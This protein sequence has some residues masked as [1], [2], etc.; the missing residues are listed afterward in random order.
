M[1]RIQSQKCIRNQRNAFRIQSMSRKHCFLQLCTWQQLL[2]FL[3]QSVLLAQW[4]LNPRKQDARRFCQRKA[5]RI[6]CISNARQLRR[7]C[8][9]LLPAQ[10]VSDCD[11]VRFGSDSSHQ[12][13]SWPGNQRRPCRTQNSSSTQLSRLQCMWHLQPGDEQERAP[14]QVPPC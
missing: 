12:A 10:H 11:Q 4:P 2:P 7:K 5:R 6:P 13:L 1:N 9:W 8:M 3:L 14:Q